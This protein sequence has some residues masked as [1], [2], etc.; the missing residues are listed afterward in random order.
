MIELSGLNLENRWEYFRPLLE[1]ETRSTRQR[2]RNDF[3][4]GFGCC[5]FSSEAYRTILTHFSR[6][7]PGLQ[8]DKMTDQLGHEVAVAFDGMLVGFTDI[9]FLPS[10]NLALETLFQQV[11]LEPDL[12]HEIEGEAIDMTSDND[13]ND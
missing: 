13:M 12:V 1:R 10:F 4:G 11:E 2:V 6:Q 8:S 5:F 3:Y 9:T 7:Y